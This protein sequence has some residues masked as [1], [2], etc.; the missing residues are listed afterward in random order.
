MKSTSADGLTISEKAA[1]ALFVPSLTVTVIGAIPNCPA[2]GVRLTAR[3]V[4]LPPNT[5]PDRGN[6]DGFADDAER[7]NPAAGV[8]ASPIVNAIPGTE[9]FITQFVA[10]IDEIVGGVFAG[11]TVSRKLALFDFPPVSTTQSV[12]V[13]CPI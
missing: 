13:D 5:I 4:A 3:F 1:L 9:E 2:T 6:S 12:I 8:S 11:A 7:L 10:A